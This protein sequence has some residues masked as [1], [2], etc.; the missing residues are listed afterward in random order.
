MKTIAAL[1]LVLVSGAAYGQLLKCVSRDGKVE[2]AAQCPSGTAEHRTAIRSS[3]PAP[4]AAPAARSLAEQEAAFRKRQL[5]QQ[6][7]QQKAEKEAALA[8]QKRQAC[9]NARAYLKSLQEGLRITRTDPKTGER[10][11]LE[12]AERAAETARAQRAVE[13][14]C[15]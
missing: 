2:Y 6:E 11:F 12:D 10:V 3:A 14:N 9:D 7:A 1:C 8:A 4:G 13:Q 15:R 5:E